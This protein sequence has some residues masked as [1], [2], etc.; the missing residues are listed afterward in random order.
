MIPES[1]INNMTI[2]LKARLKPIKN[3][4]LI[5]FAIYIS[6]F[7]VFNAGAENA[8]SVGNFSSQQGYQTNSLPEGWVPLIFKKI[9]SHTQYTLTEDNKIVVIKAT[10]RASSSGLRRTVQIDPKIYP[11]IRWRWKT[12]NIISKGDVAK[13]IGR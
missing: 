1:E 10:S 13:K 12:G 8:I 11:V 6:V 2:L 7:N 5:S 4:Y 3:I 9:K